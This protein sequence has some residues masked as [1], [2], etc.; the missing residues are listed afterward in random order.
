[1]IPTYNEREN[2]PVCVER[3][4]ALGPEYRVIVVDDGSPDGTGRIADEL[5][6]AYP[7][8][9]EVVHRPAK[10]GLGPAYIAGLGVALRSAPDLIATMD[11]DLSHDPADLVRLA[12]AVAGADLAVGS[13]FVRGGAS[14]GRSLYR[15]LLSR[16]GGRYAAAVLGV[17]VADLT[18][19][20]KM[21]RQATLERIDLDTIRSDGYV[22]SIEVTYR[23]IRRG[24]RVVEVPITF[25]D[26]VAG[27]SKFSPRIVAEAMLVVWRLR[28]S[29][30][31]ARLT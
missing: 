22:F 8:R 31:L 21:F 15:R 7:G 17:P 27:Q 10:V 9:I 11:A 18:S 30:G 12:A 13:R 2:L 20:F 1:M 28:F 6:A 5:A 14:S 16:L 19:G 29:R 24:C 26:R 4:M 3:V 25:T 23:A